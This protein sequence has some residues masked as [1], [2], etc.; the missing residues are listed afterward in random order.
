[1]NVI[2]QKTMRIREKK[3]RNRIWLIIMVQLFTYY[4]PLRFGRILV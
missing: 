2:Y 1:M 4:A 3:G